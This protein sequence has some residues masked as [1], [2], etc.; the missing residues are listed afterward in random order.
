MTINILKKNQIQKVGSDVLSYIEASALLKTYI[1]RKGL[2]SG[3]SARTYKSRLNFLGYYAYQQ[4]GGKVALDDYLKGIEKPYDF[5]AEYAAELKRNKNKDNEIRQKVKIAKKFLR[6]CGSKINNEDFTDLVTLPKKNKPDF[7]AAEKPSVIELLNNCKNQ[8]LKT[9]LLMAASLGCRKLEMCAVSNNMVNFEKDTITF[10][11][12]HTKTRQERTRRMTKELS[13]QI[14]TWNAIKYRPHRV[15]HKNGKAEIVN[16]VPHPDD[17]LLSFWHHDYKTKPEGLSDSIDVEYRELADM[18][19]IQRKAGRRVLTFHRL[20]ALVKST[21]SD[22]GYG[23]FSEWYIGHSASTYYR[24]SEKDRE[25][26]FE[27]IEPYL[28]YVDVAAME[29]RTKDFETRL[30]KSEEKYNEL[31]RIVQMQASQSA[32]PPMS[33]EEQKKYEEWLAGERERNLREDN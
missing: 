8:R 27:K 28:T 24:R 12:A 7:V 21:I 13:N 5:L 16:P 25:A 32:K 10:P 1:A 15:V 30:E 17:L 22:L 4:S 29:A 9:A 26:V 19:K 11:A 2:A 18:L 6:F 3:A 33:H 14:K 23:D 20:R 31:W